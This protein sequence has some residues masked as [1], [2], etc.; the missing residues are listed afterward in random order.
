MEKKPYSPKSPRPYLLLLVGAA[1]LMDAVFGSR[2]Q[3]WY[4]TMPPDQAK[5]IGAIILGGIFIA[6]LVGWVW[7]L[8]SRGA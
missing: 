2:M 7:F 3:A 6:G 1:A 5:A 4:Q 8:R